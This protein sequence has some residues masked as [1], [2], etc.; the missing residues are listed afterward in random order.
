MY[1]VQVSGELE[2]DIWR[3]TPERGVSSSHA[4]GFALDL[5]DTMAELDKKEP[6]TME[7][8]PVG[9]FAPADALASCYR[10]GADN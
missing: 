9:S 8:L 2:A 7:E 3:Q 4:E 5:G 6:A 1:V 10:E